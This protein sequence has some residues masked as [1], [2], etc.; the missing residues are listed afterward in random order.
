M[1]SVAPS[2]RDPQLGPV[3]VSVFS[4]PLTQLGDFRAESH[5]QRVDGSRFVVQQVVPPIRLLVPHSR[6]NS[7]LGLENGSLRTIHFTYSRRCEIFHL[8]RLRIAMRCG[9]RLPKLSSQSRFCG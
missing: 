6:R 8:E 1:R 9:A 2:F 5:A 4:E 7:L 3:F